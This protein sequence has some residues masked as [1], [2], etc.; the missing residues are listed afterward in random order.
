[1]VE[2]NNTKTRFRKFTGYELVDLPNDDV[3]SFTSLDGDP[4][5]YDGNADL[6]TPLDSEKVQKRREKS[7][8]RE[9]FYAIVDVRD[10]SSIEKV[11]AADKELFFD[12]CKDSERQNFIVIERDL[13]RKSTDK[14]YTLKNKRTGKR[15]EDISRKELQQFVDHV[16]SSQMAE[17]D[18]VKLKQEEV[19]EG[20]NRP[21]KKS[22][23]TGEFKSHRNDK[24]FKLSDCVEVDSENSTRDVAVL[25]SYSPELDTVRV[26]FDCGDLIDIDTFL[27]MSATKTVYLCDR[28]VGGEINKE[29]TFYRSE[30]SCS[31]YGKMQITREQRRWGKNG[32]YSQDVLSFEYSVAK[33]YNFTNGINSGVEPSAENLL[34]PCVQAM[35]AY[36]LDCFAWSSS[37]TMDTIIDQ[38]YKKAEIR[39]FDLSMNFR[40][41]SG[42]YKARDYVNMLSR[43]RV[44][45]QGS[46][47]EDKENP[48]KGS[49]SWGTPKSPYRVIVYDKEAEQKRYFSM[50]DGRKPLIWFEDEKGNKFK[51]Q[52]SE[53]TLKEKVYDFDE[54]RKNFYNANKDK[55]DGVFRYEVQ[56]NTKF[57]Q[58]NKLMTQGKDNIDNV[59]RI[60]QI[61]WRDILNRFDEQIGR[62]NFENTK[63]REGLAIVLDK[64]SSMKENGT[65]SR[66][67]YSNMFT[68]VTECMYRRWDVVRDEMGKA[69]F[70]NKYQWCK[71]NLNY[72]V[73]IE[74]PK[75]ADGLPIMRIMPHLFLSHEQDLLRTFRF[76]PAP[77]YKIASGE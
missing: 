58:E 18:V 41:C 48:I 76:V 30:F 16:S 29:K 20:E 40:T 39:R 72:D 67:V 8:S 37:C 56:F 62:T 31:W 19:Y 52:N 71:K 12:A 14:R 61:Y 77:V 32:M 26:Y 4:T 50:K 70:S 46:Q 64:L 75:T 13:G 51:T 65:I 15:V 74:C 23:V 3:L 45:R 25:P 34:Y 68:F 47:C 66:T 54:K 10:G 1:M 44:N 28:N 49:I 17:Y 5:D 11:S 7:K 6:C 2:N 33:W 9:I 63:E 22:R 35:C 55:F 73:K 24:K 60:G 69:N 57:M 53:G 27:P 43:C 42:I 59:L 36:E 21:K 38:F